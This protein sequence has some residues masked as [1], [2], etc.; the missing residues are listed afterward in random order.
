M[1][2]R[3]HL[4]LLLLLCSCG[5]A[6]RSDA[7]A[8]AAYLSLDASVDKAIALGFSGFNAANSANIPPQMTNGALTG[9]LRVTGQVDQ[10]ASAN[11][12]M[13]LHVE[14][15]GYSD[16][17]K[18]SYA[19]RATALPALTMQL[20][21]IPDGTLSGTLVGTVNM[22]GAQQ[23]ELNFNLAFTGSLQPGAGTKVERKPGTTHVTGTATSAAGTFMV[24]VTH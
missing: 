18:I 20:K 1:P 17:G 16:D 8:R 3:A 12:G 5:D 13:R 21:N 24:D 22:T 11:K 14:L 10:G 19:T 23:G 6:V 7:D 2:R 15:T 9:T 4:P